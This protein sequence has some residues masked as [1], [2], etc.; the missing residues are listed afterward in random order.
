MSRFCAAVK[1]DL[2]PPVDDARIEEGFHVVDDAVL[3]YSASQ[4]APTHC[5]RTW[6]PA[7]AMTTGDPDTS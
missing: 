3:L 4:F 5:A 1:P 6:T 7:D 2:Q